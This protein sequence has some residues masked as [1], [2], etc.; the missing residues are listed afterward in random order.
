MTKH[1][2]FPTPVWH[3]EGAP[4]QLVE[5]LYE[6]AYKFKEKYE[7]VTKSNKGG[8]QTPILEWEMFHPEG[9]K[10]INNVVGDIFKFKVEGWWY[11][12]NGQGDWNIPHTHPDV[13]IALVLYVTDSD[14]LLAFMNPHP[15]RLIDDQCY[16]GP[17]DYAAIKA[18][19]GDIIMFPSDLVHYV[20]PN[21]RK[22][23]RISISMNISII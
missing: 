10:Y 6:G 9:K 20:L 21:P 3:I 17:V 4:Q 1:E 18:N 12:I 5:E 8:Y 11:N 16:G 13:N 15:M 2:I 23:D 14:G 7:S 22:E 19:K